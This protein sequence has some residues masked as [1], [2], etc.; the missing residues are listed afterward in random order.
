[1]TTVRGDGRAFDAVVVKTTGR[2]R[3]RSLALAQDY[4]AARRD[5]GG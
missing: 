4:A 1:M 2:R 5:A 3:A